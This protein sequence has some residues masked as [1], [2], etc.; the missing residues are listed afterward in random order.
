MVARKGVSAMLRTIIIATTALLSFAPRVATGAGEPEPIV[1][2]SEIEHVTVYS[3]RAAVERWARD[4]E[5]QPGVV[6]VVFKDLP[7]SLMQE[8]VRASGEGTA[9]CGIA[10]VD[11]KR[12]YLGEVANARADTLERAYKQLE[13]ERKD[14]L[15]KKEAY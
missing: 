12:T 5:V 9:R 13:R 3:D 6:R 10:N 2:S 7:T 14:V 15:A 8:S 11:V 1:A 4:I